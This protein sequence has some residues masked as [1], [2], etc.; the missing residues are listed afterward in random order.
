MTVRGVPGGYQL[1]S[2]SFCDRP[3]REVH[4]VAGRDGLHICSVCVEN[5]ATILDQDANVP[6][7]P[8]GWTDRWPH[9]NL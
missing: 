9:K 1:V 3:N 5:C 8:G 2:C 7:P 4:I 6:S